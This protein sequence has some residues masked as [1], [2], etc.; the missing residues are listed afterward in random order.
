MPKGMGYK[1]PKTLGRAAGKLTAMG[2]RN[3]G[4]KPLAKLNR[5]KSRQMRK[6]EK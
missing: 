1:K 2:L 3:L 5:A 4:G 6:G